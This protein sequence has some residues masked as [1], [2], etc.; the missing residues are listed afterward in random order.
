MVELNISVQHFPKW[1]KQYKEEET[2]YVI[3]KECKKKKNIKFTKDNFCLD[4][5]S[6]ENL[7]D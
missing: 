1:L 7:N 3:C 2:I 4:C 5:I 6:E